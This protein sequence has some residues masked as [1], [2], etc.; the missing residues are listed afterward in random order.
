[1]S[2]KERD[3]RYYAAHRTERIAAVMR[4]YRPRRFERYGLTEAA[5]EEIFVRQGSRC[6]VCLRP[7]PGT[8]TGWHTDHDHLTGETRGI[9]CH[10]CNTA[11]GL[12]KDNVPT[13]LSMIK[14][15][16]TA[17]EQRASEEKAT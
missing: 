14:Y 3:A 5:W 12:V 1:M 4:T 11:L 2:R 7:E 15:L 6:A 9:L 17:V 8:K 10:H 13:L 16:T